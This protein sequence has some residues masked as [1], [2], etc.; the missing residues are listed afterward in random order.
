[1]LK[2]ISKHTVA[3]QVIEQLTELIRDGSLKPGDKLPSEKSMAEQLG[4][5]RPPLR[6]SLRAL[7]YAGVIETRYG[8]GIY[9]KSTDISALGNVIISRLLNR[10]CLAEVIELRTILESGMVELAANRAGDDDLE[11]LRAIQ[12]KSRTDMSNIEQFV[13]GDFAFHCAIA[14]ATRNSMLFDTVRALQTV[15]GEFNQELLNNQDRREEA[16]RQHE[17]IFAAIA[18][19]NAKA[20]VQAMKE[21]LGNVL[22]MADRQR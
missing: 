13:D 18:G 16:H 10:S 22:H 2:K 7:E 21:H 1:M 17:T 14:E 19:H 6:E 4:V 3:A 8:D 15:M 20:A 5:S 9:I 11:A 12:S